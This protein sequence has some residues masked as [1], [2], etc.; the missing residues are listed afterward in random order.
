MR[1]QCDLLAVV[2]TRSV[3]AVSLTCE[4]DTVRPAHDDVTRRL[5]LALGAAWGLPALVNRE[6]ERLDLRHVLAHLLE[7]RIALGA[8]GFRAESLLRPVARGASDENERNEQRQRMLKRRRHFSAPASRLPAFEP[9]DLV[10]YDVSTGTALLTMSGESP[11]FE[12]AF[13]AFTSPPASP[14]NG[15]NVPPTGAA[16]SSESMPGTAVAICEKSLGLRR[17][18]A[19][20]NS[21]PAAPAACSGVEP[22]S[23]DSAPTSSGLA[24]AAA[25]ASV[26]V[27]N[28]LGAA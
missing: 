17:D 27:C 3:S 21:A 20:P 19:T 14:P 6:G 22:I 28:A 4:C 12:N 1:H 13:A 25:A 9:P 24:L 16:L 5:P 11:S 2:P 10:T 18:F 23:F 26:A 7:Q 8:G 15:D